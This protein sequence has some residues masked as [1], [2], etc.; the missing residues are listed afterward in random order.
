MTMR[1]ASLRAAA[2][3]SSTVFRPEHTTIPFW[4]EVPGVNFS[5]T[6]P[7][8]N[9]HSLFATSRTTDFG[10]LGRLRID[11]SFSYYS[12][13]RPQNIDQLKLDIFVRTFFF[14][15]E[16]HVFYPVDQSRDV[17]FISF[18]WVVRHLI[19]VRDNYFGNFTHFSTLGEYVTKR[20][21]NQPVGDPVEAKWREG[22]V[23]SCGRFLL[24]L[25]STS[26]V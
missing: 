3:I 23:L 16:S 22:K 7:R 4:V 6:L 17:V 1:G 18:G 14:V 9:T 2:K 19:A 11:A 5:L 13:T 21:Q 12:D 8:W 15:L 24:V 10:C 20:H 26:V 25:T